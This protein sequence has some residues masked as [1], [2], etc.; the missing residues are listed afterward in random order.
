MAALR[1]HIQLVCHFATTTAKDPAILLRFRCE[2]LSLIDFVLVA[3]HQRDN[4]SR[5]EAKC[6]R[7]VPVLDEGT[8][9]GLPLL[10]RLEVQ[11]SVAGVWPSICSETVVLRR[12]LAQSPNWDIAIATS[13]KTAS[14]MMG[15]LVTSFAPQP[16][17]SLLEQKHN[18]R[19]CAVAMQALRT[20]MRGGEEV[21]ASG[22]RR[23]RV[24]AASGHVGP[25]CRAASGHAKCVSDSDDSDVSETQAY[26]DKIIA[27]LNQKAKAEKSRVAVGEDLE[28]PVVASGHVTESGV[29]PLPVDDADADAARQRKKGKNVEEDYGNVWITRQYR[30]GEPYAF[31][32]K[33]NRHTNAG[34]ELACARELTIGSMSHGEAKRRLK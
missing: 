6:L 20:A 8:F 13:R 10:L 4:D 11:S 26:W 31:S 17:D 15:S 33:C 22:S 9:D 29:E 16:C 30:S 23:R 21:K 14:P 24:G 5:F 2:G 3:H 25:G 19:E 27:S 18:E 32:I 1:D 7:M 12:L 28:D 34:C